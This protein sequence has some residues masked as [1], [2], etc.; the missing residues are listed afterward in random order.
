MSDR[1]DSSLAECRTRRVSDIT[2]L[3]Q[4]TLRLIPRGSCSHTSHP[5]RPP[6]AGEDECAIPKDDALDPN[7]LERTR[8]PSVAFR[9]SFPD[10][11]CP[12]QGRFDNSGPPPPGK[13]RE[14]AD[15]TGLLQLSAHPFR[16]LH[17]PVN[18]PLW[19]RPMSASGV[20]SNGG[21]RL[22]AQRP[23]DLGRGNIVKLITIE[24]TWA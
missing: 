19:L 3:R 13:A 24:R 21:W 10:Q 6:S 15:A 23:P 7:D 8:G 4:D 12:D 5:E 22:L 2:A 11:V 18:T 17:H 14:R 9:S 20:G 1:E 16:S